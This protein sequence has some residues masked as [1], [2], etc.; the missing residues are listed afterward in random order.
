MR[1]EQPGRAPARGS[2]S[3]LGLYTPTMRVAMLQAEIPPVGPGGVGYQVDLVATHLVRRGHDVTVF[4]ANDPPTGK[5]YRCVQA[6]LR[7]EG[8]THRQLGVGLAFARLDL[9]GFDVIHAHGDDWAFLGRQRVRTFYGTALMEAVSA[10]SILRFGSQLCYYVLEWLSSLSAEGVVISRD[11]KR[12]LPLARR[13]IPCAFDPSIFFPG[14]DRT[15]NPSILFVAGT[16]KGRKR[17][18][19]LLETFREVRRTIPDATLTIVSSD[20]VSMPGVTSLSRVTPEVLGQLYRRHWLLCSTSSYE[21][22]G[23][24]YVEALA[25]GLPVVAT[26]N[27]GARE[28]LEGGRF[29]IL[30]SPDELASSLIEVIGD[31]GRRRELS[32]SGPEAARQYSTDVVVA[33]YERLYEY[34]RQRSAA[35]QT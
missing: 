12:F 1:P 7:R 10:T 25:A 30:C 34:V 8:R 33:D 32:S 31:E 9:T 35:L 26:S 19:L 11:T 3:P 21:G 14:G 13:H 20:S 15:G 24:P 28:V 23:L 16:L 22:L 18:E 5:T 2:R 27:T 4:T 29:G 17:G 6:H